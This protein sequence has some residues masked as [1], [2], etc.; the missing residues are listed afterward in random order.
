MDEDT[1]HDDRDEAENDLKGAHYYHPEGG[2]LNVLF[3]LILYGCCW[4]GISLLWH[5][6]VGHCRVRA[7]LAVYEDGFCRSSCCCGGDDAL[8]K[9]NGQ[10]GGR[11]LLHGTIRRLESQWN[12]ERTEQTLPSLQ[13]SLTMHN[14]QRQARQNPFRRCFRIQS[15]NGAL[16]V[17]SA[18]LSMRQ[19]NPTAATGRG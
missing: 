5:C 3:L 4:C 8:R 17:I 2:L 1:G 9:T 18:A 14:A 15:G 13:Q 12:F 10:R 7:G 19:Y 11:R 16:L 6:G